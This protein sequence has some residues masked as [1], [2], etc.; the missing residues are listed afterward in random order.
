VRVVVVALDG[1]PVAV[2]G[3]V[4]RSR[5]RRERSGAATR[6]HLPA[7]GATRPRRTRRLGP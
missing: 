7:P 2:D 3:R 4:P 1:S 5:H 6:D